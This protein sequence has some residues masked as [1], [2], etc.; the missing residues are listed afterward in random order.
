MSNPY[1]PY[2]QPMP[3]QPIYPQG[4]NF[5]PYQQQPIPQPTPMNNKPVF[6]FVNGIE[7]AKSYV[8]APNRTAIL[9]DTENA[10][11]YIKACNNIGQASIQFYSISATTE[12][13]IRAQK[14][15]EEMAGFVPREEFSGISDRL[16][17][18]EKML[19]PKDQP[20]EGDKQ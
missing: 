7:G 6:D 2:I 17:S 9:M 18:I 5:G 4:Y 19:A 12:D 11:V 20:K 14:R 1:N 3:N 13:G 8:V 15:K 10:A 16:A